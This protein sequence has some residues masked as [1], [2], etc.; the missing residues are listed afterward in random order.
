MPPVLLW[1]AN[2]GKGGVVKSNKVV[3]GGPLVKEYAA[4]LKGEMKKMF[5]LI[6]ESQDFGETRLIWYHENSVDL[7]MI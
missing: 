3:E 1:L 4:F 7:I 2:E 6:Y 5:D